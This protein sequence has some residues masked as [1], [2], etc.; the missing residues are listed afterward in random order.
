MY[1]GG[2]RAEMCDEGTFNQIMSEMPKWTMAI[3]IIVIFLLFSGY[4][5]FF[6]WL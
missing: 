5:I 6:E 1:S 3:L 2:N 4:F